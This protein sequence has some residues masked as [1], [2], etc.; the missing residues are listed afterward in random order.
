MVLSVAAIGLATNA[1]FAGAVDGPVVQLV[2]DHTPGSPLEG[3]DAT[4]SGGSTSIEVLADGVQVG[5]KTFEGDEK[6]TDVAEIPIPVSTTS[7]M[8]STSSSVS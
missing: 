3:I 8:L 5:E 1:P 4:F 2:V 7:T 6:I